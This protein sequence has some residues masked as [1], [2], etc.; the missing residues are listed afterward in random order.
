VRVARHEKRLG[1]CGLGTAP[2]A[3]DH[4][5]LFVRVNPAAADARDGVSGRALR[6]ERVVGEE[7]GRGHEIQ[8]WLDAR[9]RRQT[10]ESFVILD[11]SAD[12]AH[13]LPRLVRTPFATGLG[14]EHVDQAVAMLGG[15]AR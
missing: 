5:P 12:M 15:A 2:T 13:L 7:R 11:D 10:I 1:G 9:A 3:D 14:D 6:T 4:G 8:A